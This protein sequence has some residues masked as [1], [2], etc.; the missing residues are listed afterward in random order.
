MSVRYLYDSNGSYVAFVHGN[1]VFDAETNWL[2]VLRNGNEFF[3]KS[4]KFLGYLLSDDRIAY[5]EGESRGS[6]LAPMRPLQP[7]RPLR[8]LQRLKAG[9]L[10]PPYR[11]LFLSNRSP[12]SSTSSSGPKAASVRTYEGCEIVAHDDTFLGVLSKNRYDQRSI[13]NPYSPF[14]SRYSSQSIFNKY[15]TYGSKYSK[16]SPFSKYSSTPPRLLRGGK[17]AAYL[18]V[19]KLLSPRVSPEDVIAY[20]S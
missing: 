7:L 2:G 1:H 3:D 19:S 11:D 5:R 15:G 6:I 4:G 10:P 17:L 20:L 8:P 18:T 9:S 16:F 12:A 14:G 13:A